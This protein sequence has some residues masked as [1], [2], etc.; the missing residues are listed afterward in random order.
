MWYKPIH[1][2][3]TFIQA[4]YF[5]RYTQILNDFLVEPNLKLYFS[6][7]SLISK[8]CLRVSRFKWTFLQRAVKTE[9]ELDA[10]QIIARSEELAQEREH[11]NRRKT[12]L[13]ECYVSSCS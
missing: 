10:Q 9:V 4:V 12:I 7:Y 6:L 11:K 2:I 5:K 8:N 13:Q 1:S 3:A